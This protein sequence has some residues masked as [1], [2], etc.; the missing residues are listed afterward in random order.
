MN[1]N[2]SSQTRSGRN[3]QKKLREPSTI[4]TRLEV[5]SGNGSGPN[6]AKMLPIPEPLKLKEVDKLKIQPHVSL[7]PSNLR[8]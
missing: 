5:I 2:P 6:E 4:S 1:L 7:S 8:L 3:I